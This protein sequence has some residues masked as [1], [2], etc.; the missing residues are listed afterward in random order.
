VSVYYQLS[1]LTTDRQ[2]RQ[3]E[4]AV[5]AHSSRFSVKLDGARHSGQYNEIEAAEE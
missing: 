4:R 1:V 3:L 5:P 2:S